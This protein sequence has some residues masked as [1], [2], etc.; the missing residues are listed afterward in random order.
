MQTVVP[1]H[2]QRYAWQLPGVCC[3]LHSIQPF[4]SLFVHDSSAGRIPLP[5][6]VGM[7]RKIKDGVGELLDVKLQFKVIAENN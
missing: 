4:H 2:T 3:L 6:S 1:K 5:H 7:G